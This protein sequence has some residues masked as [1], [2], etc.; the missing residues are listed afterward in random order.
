MHVQIK[1]MRD[2]IE[3]LQAAAKEA[4]AREKKN[5]KYPSAETM[6]TLSGAMRIKSKFTKRYPLGT[7]EK[8]WIKFQTALKKKKDWLNVFIKLY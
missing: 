7:N 2:I 1:K 8:K 6:K 3:D 5:P 4:A